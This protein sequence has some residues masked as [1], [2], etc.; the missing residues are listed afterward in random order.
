MQTIFVSL[1]IIASATS[2]TSTAM[3]LERRRTLSFGRG[4]EA[5]IALPDDQL[6]NRHFSI[7]H[8]T[9]TCQLALLD[10]QAR[11][12]LNGRSVQQATLKDRDQI[13]AGQTVIEIRIEDITQIR[14]QVLAHFKRQPKPFYAIVDPAQD[15]SIYPLLEEYSQTLK[16]SL[17]EGKQGQ[18][19]ITEAPHLIQF[20]SADD[21]LLEH[22]VM[23][24]WGNNWAVYL[25]APLIFETVR[26]HLRQCL[27]V[28]TDDD[29]VVF[30]FYDPRVFVD[31][32]S[33][34]NLE[35]LTAFFGP[36]HCYFLENIDTKQ[37][38]R[39]QLVQPQADHQT[40]HQDRSQQYSTYSSPF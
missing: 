40:P 26:R 39:S 28:K 4:S 12:Y 24:G 22:L 33:G 3:P 6:H 17:F 11:L 23:R 1:Q 35:Q 18:A 14:Q 20:S 31:I 37:I 21:P 15:K 27:R 7:Q 36:I 34:F 8:D 9:H 38:I 10:G 30:R 13:Q 29:Y 32:I 16:Q 19:V 25:S 2:P 5:D